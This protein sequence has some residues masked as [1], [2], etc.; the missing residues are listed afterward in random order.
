MEL[1]CKQ[2]SHIFLFVN[3]CLLFWLCFGYGLFEP[4]NSLIM[5]MIRTSFVEINKGGRGTQQDKTTTNS[6]NYIYIDLPR[7]GFKNSAQKFWKSNFSR[8]PSLNSTCDIAIN[9]YRWV[10]SGAIVDESIR[11]LEIKEKKK[12]LFFF[13]EVPRTNIECNYNCIQMY[14]KNAF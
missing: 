6:A 5:I 9:S 13:S 14:V 10:C 3:C 4:I 11:C 8:S 7:M 1:N 12:K 2:K